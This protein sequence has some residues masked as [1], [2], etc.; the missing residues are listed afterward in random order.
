M[1]NMDAD[2]VLF[3]LGDHG[4]TQTGDHGGDS[5]DETSAALFVY[6]PTVLHNEES[7]RNFIK[8]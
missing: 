2:T 8:T 7:V 5:V 1:S 4:M 6:S 3:V